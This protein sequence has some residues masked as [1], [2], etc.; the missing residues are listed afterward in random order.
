VDPDPD[1]IGSLLALDWLLERLGK[2]SQPLSHDGILPQWRFLPRIERIA[3]PREPGAWS[4][5]TWDALVVVDCEVSRTGSAAAW[6]DR[7]E[8]VINSDHHV[9]SPGTGH[10][11]PV[12]P[13]AAAAGAAGSRPTREAGA[14]LAADAATRPSA[15]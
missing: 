8:R 7:V 12:A 15:P 3:S 2:R 5:E 6:A 1:C 9:T 13:A 4:E 11:H 10:I 14:P